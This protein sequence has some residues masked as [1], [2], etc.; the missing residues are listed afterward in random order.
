MINTE[1]DCSTPEINKGGFE[2]RNASYWKRRAD[3]LEI[4]LNHA[5]IES[6]RYQWLKDRLQEA[7]D[8]NDLETGDMA[9]RCS[10]VYGRRNERCVEGFIRWIDI[11]DEPLNLDAA[12]DAEMTRSTT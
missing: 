10:M 6:A 5:R 12:V 9:T 4:E 3:K 11:R 2:V 1:T 7:Y 8:G